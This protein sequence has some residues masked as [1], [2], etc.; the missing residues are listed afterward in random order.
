MN[1]RLKEMAQEICFLVLKEEWNQYL[2][3]LTLQGCV[4]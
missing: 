3:K 2:A 1:C 4:T